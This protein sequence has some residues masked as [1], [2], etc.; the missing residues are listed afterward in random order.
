[1]RF[2]E[3]LKLEKARFLQEEKQEQKLQFDQ[4]VGPCRSIVEETFG[5]AQS[6]SNP[7]LESIARVSSTSKQPLKATSEMTSTK[8]KFQLSSNSLN[9]STQSLRQNHA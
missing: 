4:L 7:I 5:S 8:V 3:A 9:S 2:Q 6:W 1:M